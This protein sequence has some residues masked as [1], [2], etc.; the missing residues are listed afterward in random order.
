[1]FVLLYRAQIL[2]MKYLIHKCMFH[3]V[4]L[5]VTYTL[6][7]YGF[8][9][10]IFSGFLHLTFITFT[11]TIFTAAGHG[12]NCIPPPATLLS[13]IKMSKVKVKYDFVLFTGFA[14][15]PLLL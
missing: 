15:I 13:K 1:M 7:V 9:V 10:T 11:I 8:S 4:Q 6:N 2:D 14:G 3:V 5:S 12:V